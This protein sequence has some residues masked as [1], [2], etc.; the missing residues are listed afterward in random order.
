LYYC[1]ELLLLVPTAAYYC[2][3]YCTYCCVYLLLL[4]YCRFYLLPRIPTAA[5]TY[6]CVY[7]LLLVLHVLPGLLLLVPTAALCSSDNN[8]ILSSGHF[9]LPPY[10]NQDTMRYLRIMKD[11]YVTAHCVFMLRKGSPFMASINSVIRKLRDRGVILFWEDMAVRR[12]M[13][14]SDQLAVI[15]SRSEADNGPTQLLLRHTQVSSEFFFA[16]AWRVRRL[17]V[18]QTA[19]TCSDYVLESK[20]KNSI[21]PMWSVHVHVKKFCCQQMSLFCIYRGLLQHVSAM[22][23]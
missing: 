15:G 9:A 7:L 19:S 14:N 3:L 6:C 5:C 4:Y 13:S 21:L 16:V 1:R 12:Y 11:D 23:L 8:C 22:F 17:W 18:E 2:C 20:K 10:I